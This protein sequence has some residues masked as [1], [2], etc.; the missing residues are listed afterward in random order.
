MPWF[1][2]KFT[3]PPDQ[4]AF[5]L[6][7]HGHHRDAKFRNSTKGLHKDQTIGVISSHVTTIQA[8][9]GPFIVAENI[10]PPINSSNLN[11]INQFSVKPELLT[12]VLPIHDPTIRVMFRWEKKV[13]YSNGAADDSTGQEPLPCAKLVVS[14]DGQE[15]AS[16]CRMQGGV[17]ACVARQQIPSEWWRTMGEMD[18]IKAVY[19]VFQ[20]AENAPCLPDNHNA[21]PPRGEEPATASPEHYIGEVKLG[22]LDEGFSINEEDSYVWIHSPV[23]QFGSGAKF[24]VPVS[25]LGN[26]TATG[27]VIR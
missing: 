12:T 2:A 3:T 11:E 13:D 14:Y 10:T 25:I 7:H 24:Q 5:L 21:I 19:S 6:A 22:S 15:L 27:C 17:L 18:S 26:F 1:P 20:V 9:Y 8:T 16:A 4:S 23:Q